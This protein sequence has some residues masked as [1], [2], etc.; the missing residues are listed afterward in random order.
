MQDQ[1]IRLSV[2]AEPTY[3]RTVRML[4]ANLAV[5]SGMSVDDVEDMRMA[6]EEGFVFACATKPGVCDIAFDV[7]AGSLSCSFTLGSER[8]QEDDTSEDTPAWAYADLILSAVCDS[9][10]VDADA[11]RLSLTKRTDAAHAV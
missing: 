9:Y 2:P 7:A 3:A 5:V 10:E 1:T 11:G 6:A 8:A 4:A